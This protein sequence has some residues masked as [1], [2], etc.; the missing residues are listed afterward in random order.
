MSQLVRPGRPTVNLLIG[1]TR[2]ARCSP[3]H[4]RNHHSGVCRRQITN[5]T[6]DEQGT[7]KPQQEH[8]DKSK[9][10]GWESW[11]NSTPLAIENRFLSS[12][13]YRTTTSTAFIS[14]LPRCVRVLLV[15]CT[16][17]EHLV[18]GLHLLGDAEGSLHRRLLSLHCCWSP[19]RKLRF[20][21]RGTQPFY[22]LVDCVTDNL[23]KHN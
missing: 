10:H 22:S 18:F 20:A 19:C 21:A 15:Y 12:V 14:L 16:L 7:N 6:H 8:R 23:G 13:G 1:S 4:R 2:F 5:G 17:P 11:R 9:G 3:S